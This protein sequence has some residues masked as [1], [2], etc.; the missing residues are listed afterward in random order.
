MRQYLCS[1]L[2]ADAVGYTRLKSINAQLASELLDDAHAVFRSACA[3]HQGRVVDMADDSVRLAFD[4]AANALRCAMAVQLHLTT[5]ISV[6]TGTLRLP[7]RIGLHLGEVIENSD[8]SV[9]GDAVTLAAQL[10]R[11]AEPGEVIVSQPVHDLLAT[12]S[13][14]GFEDAGEHR[15]NG[16]AEPA[17]AWRALPLGTAAAGPAAETIAGPMRFG[18]QG[19]FELQPRERRLLVDGEPAALGARAFDLLLALAAQPGVLLTRNALIDAVWPG[20][21]VE[22]NNLAVQVSALRKLLGGEVIVT[23]PGRGYRFAARLHSA[24][25]A[26]AVAAADPLPPSAAIAAPAQTPTPAQLKTNLPEHLPPLLGRSEDLAALQVLVADHALVALVGAG[27]VGKSTLARSLLHAHRADRARWT[28]GV[29][30]VELAAVSDR[31]ALPGAV[32][33][34]LGVEIRGDDALAALCAAVAPLTMLVALDNAEHQLD[35]VAQLTQALLDAAPGL[36]LLVTSQAPLKLA[37]ERVYRLD[38]LAVPQ[39][40]LPAATARGFG[41]VALFV[42]RA[43][44]ADARF[45]LT[46]ANAPAVIEICRALDGLALAIELAA[47]RAPMLGLQ[48]LASSMQDRL[49]LLT[50]SRNRAAPA[51][52]Q[53][54][55]A[56]LEW[57]H[58]FLEE[59]ERAV[60][61][62]LSVFVGSGSLAMIQQVLSDPPGPADPAVALDDWSVLDA[63]VLLVD[64]SLVVVLNG[65]EGDR[66]QEPRYRLLESPLAYAREQLA[67][68]GEQAALRQ[69]HLHAVAAHCEA[70]CHCFDSG[71]I[72]WGDWH[73]DFA[74]DVDNALEALQQAITLGASAAAVQVGAALLQYGRSRRPLAENQ[75]VF[76]RVAGQ[77][78]NTLPPELQVRWWLQVAG[79]WSTTQGRRSLDAAQQAR[80]ALQRMPELPGNRYL[81]Y[82]VACQLAL[83]ASRTGDRLLE[84]T[85]LAEANALEDPHWPP[86]RLYCKAAA[87]SFG[88][89]QRTAQAGDKDLSQMRELLAL[90]LAAGGNGFVPRNNLM[91]LQLAAGDAQAAVS[92]GEA[93]LADLERSREGLIT[94]AIAQL[95]LVA[96]LLGLQDLSRA[97]ERAQTGWPQGR[98]YELQ[99]PWA[100]YLALLAALEGR[101]QSA[102]RLTGYADAGYA[103]RDDRRE[104]NESTAVERASGLA[105]AALG[106][107]EFERLA[108][109]GA[110]LR[111]E[112]IAAIAF[113]TRAE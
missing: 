17:R 73:R 76:E 53:T 29:C 84:Q 18:A 60:F 48:R 69:R 105:R 101:L 56:A 2:A 11:Q 102:A 32:A 22:E 59:R 51:R 70:A 43:H 1:I 80:S 109:D 10:Q 23:I 98:L 63:L 4:G 99:A 107:A 39:G 16:A 15:L 49:R 66:P 92:T 55:R 85:G 8:G 33:A 75:T 77:L 71:D 103:L 62:R 58:G 38:T 7:F 24:A 46:D 108:A 79:T 45:V 72:G 88:L 50:T 93:L 20:L 40:P 74:L 86:H 54:L 9:S 61:R 12:R 3:A 47:A 112:Q 111:D 96:A 110:R 78:G 41:A 68:A 83:V 14:A 89:T 104:R 37:A 27:G 100:D 44:A 42:E 30:W 67:A 34:A 28:H 13:I 57:S 82:K 94:A 113:A 65:D 64:R 35:G 81:R 106:D 25:A 90:D 31:A 26:G 36:R 6:D 19:R 91:D 21:V 87:A 5:Q 95:N 97:R 52:Q